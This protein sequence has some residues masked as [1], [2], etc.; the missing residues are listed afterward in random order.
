MNIAQLK[1]QA[2]DA[3]FQNAFDSVELEDV[4][5]NVIE[6]IDFEP[7][8][9]RSMVL[10]TSNEFPPGF[11]DGVRMPGRKTISRF[12]PLEILAWVRKAENELHKEADEAYHAKWV[13]IERQRA[14]QREQDDAREAELL[15]SETAE[16]TRQR[17]QAIERLREKMGNYSI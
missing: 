9:G 16:Q 17:Y 4:G 15:A 5:K 1:Q 6:I 11:P 14:I 8:L 13:E 10:K 3:L 12:D 7:R 2:L